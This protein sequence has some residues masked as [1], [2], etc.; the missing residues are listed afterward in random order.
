M[1]GR[2]DGRYTGSRDDQIVLIGTHYDSTQTTLGVDDN[3]SGMAAMLTAIKQ[4]KTDGE[5]S[6]GAK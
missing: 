2:L 5:L 1:I 3:G 4:I 6:A